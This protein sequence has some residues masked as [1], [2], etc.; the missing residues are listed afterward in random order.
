[1]NISYAITV[2]NEHVELNR[3]LE[4]LVSAITAGS[5]IVVQCDIGNTTDNVRDVLDKFSEHVR[6]VEY[7]LDRNFAAFKNNLKR[8]CKCEWIF[9]IDADEYPDE[10]LIAMLPTILE[11]NKDVDV[12]WVPRINTV[13]GLQAEDIRRWKWNVDKNGRVNFPDYQCRIFRNLPEI[14][15]QNAVHEVI[16]G[17]RSHGQLPAN[18]EYCLI[19]PKT[20]DRQRRQN[21][22]YS[23][24]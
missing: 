19:H 6:V 11:S 8:C 4:Q 15:W 3:L 7:A 23:T 2:H 5:E 10:Y 12:L 21:A 18:D 16:K 24:I 1:M 17:H 9:Q 20:I 14:E 22:F 13:D